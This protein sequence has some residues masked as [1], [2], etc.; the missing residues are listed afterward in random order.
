MMQD[1]SFEKIIE[2]LRDKDA[3]IRAA[4]MYRLSEPLAE[5]MAAL[6]TAWHTI[7]VERRRLLLARMYETSEN[8][9]E[10]DYADV[11]TFALEDDDAEVRKFAVKTL[12]TEEKPAVMHRLIELLK[13]DPAA[14]VRA[15][16]AIAL[17]HFV[18]LGEIEDISETDLTIVVDALLKA[19]RSDREP[20]EV[21]RRALEGIGF[22]SHKDVPGLIESASKHDQHKMRIS[23][24]FAMGRSCDKRWKNQILRGLDDENLE[25]RFE[26]TRAAGEMSLKEAVTRLIE[27]T[28]ELD[29][30]IKAMAI[31]SLGEIGG[32][33]ATRALYELEDSE[34]DDELL[35]LIEDALSMAQLASL[36]DP[37]EDDPD[38]NLDLLDF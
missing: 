1:E 34:D 19:H 10:M 11:A 35:E 3:A 24:M 18:W 36:I 38:I 14:E 21:R 9:F 2:N 8:S 6:K 31:W 5:D 37:D 32:Q 30:E 4:V 33:A 16:A 26:A 17:G 22:S 23:A 20:L 7:P 15:A 28:R 13:N 27:L 25:F 12:W 29:E